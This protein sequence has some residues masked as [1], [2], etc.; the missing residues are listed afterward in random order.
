MNP[1]KVHERAGKL[2]SAWID[3]ELTQ[4]EAQLVEIHLAD[5]AECARAAREMRSLRDM[6]AAVPFPN[7]PDERLDEL[8]SALSVQA[9]RLTGW[10]L[11]VVGLLAWLGWNIVMALRSLRMPTPQEAMSGAIF[12]GIVLLFVSVVRQRMLEYSHDRYRRVKR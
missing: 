3:Q 8:G 12:A 7:G 10:V 5:C 1:A 11:I 6:T 4:E 2:I 9:P